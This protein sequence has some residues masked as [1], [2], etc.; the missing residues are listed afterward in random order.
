M[1]GP[2]VVTGRQFNAERVDRLFGPDTPFCYCRRG[3]H[4]V[5]IEELAYMHPSVQEECKSLFE[6]AIAEYKL[7]IVATSNSTAKIDPVLIQRFWPRINFD[8][9]P[10]FRTASLDRLGH[11]WKAETGCEELPQGW[12][13][14]GG[15]IAETK[16]PSLYQE[17]VLAPPAPDSP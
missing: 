2:I 7:L 13:H 8:G 15:G 17:F 16:N 4:V 1:N 12:L 6:Q 5:I 14:W 3:F 10:C 11:I 9:G